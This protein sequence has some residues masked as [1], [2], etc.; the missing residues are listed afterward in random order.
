VVRAR[1]LA[2]AD[3]LVGAVVAELLALIAE[4]LV[5]LHGPSQPAF[6]VEREPRGLAVDQDQ[7]IHGSSQEQLEPCGVDGP[8]GR[9]ARAADGRR[10]GSGTAAGTAATRRS[11]ASALEAGSNTTHDTPMG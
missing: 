11:G 2:A 8:R 5:R 1:A 6:T 4:R 9:A 3:E 7:E 10:A